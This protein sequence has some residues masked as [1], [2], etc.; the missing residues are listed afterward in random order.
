MNWLLSWP[1]GDICVVKLEFGVPQTVADGRDK[2]ASHNKSVLPIH[3][4]LLWH[5]IDNP[6]L[7]VG[8]LSIANAGLITG[9]AEKLGLPV[10]LHVIGP[11]GTFDYGHEI[12][13]D[14]DNAELS[15]TRLANPFSSFH[16]RLR[17][18]DVVFDIGAG[19]SF[20]DI[21]A[22]KRFP[23]MILSKFAAKLAGARLVLSPQTIG[24]FFGWQAKIAAR[25]ALSVCDHTF[26]RDQ[27]SRDYLSELGFDAKS[28]L[29]TDVAFALPYTVQETANRALPGE[30]EPVRV[31]LNVS[32]LLYRAHRSP[33]ANVRLR[34]DYPKLIY[35]IV[36]RLS[37]DEAYEVHLIAHVINSEDAPIPEEGHFEDDYS[38]AQEIQARFPGCVVAPKFETPIEAKSYIAGMDVFAGSRM[39]STIAAISSDTAVIPLGYSRKFNGLFD[40]IGYNWNIDLTQ[41]GEDDALVSFF[42]AMGRIDALKRDAIAANA[43]ARERLRGYVAFIESALLEAAARRA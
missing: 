41:I 27:L 30:P 14:W 6:N 37:A 13:G 24:P 16:Q 9:A 23:L 3:V 17:Q 43:Q 42:E 32:G 22:G 21:Y 36:E 20:S 38:T 39:H 15:R 5:S 7:G 40:S 29:T 18:C 19:D 33:H 12:P 8:A 4:G 1:R 25:A 34:A 10:T 26:A 35:R 2:T 31:G 28:S 11:A